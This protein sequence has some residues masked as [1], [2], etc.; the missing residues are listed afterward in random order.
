LGTLN[1]ELRTW[2]VELKR[3]GERLFPTL[4]GGVDAGDENPDELIGFLGECL[5]PVRV[6][7]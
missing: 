6:W 2:N 5:E 3:R 4:F 7:E 1:V